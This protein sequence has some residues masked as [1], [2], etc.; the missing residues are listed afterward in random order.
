MHQ[1]I[2]GQWSQNTEFTFTCTMLNH[3]KQFRLCHITVKAGTTFST[4]HDKKTRKSRPLDCNT[5]AQI[6]LFAST[7]DKLTAGLMQNFCLQPKRFMTEQTACALVHGDA[8]CSI[9]RTTWMCAA[10]PSVTV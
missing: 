9:N 5:E 8:N 10:V 3:T 4:K 7:W 2:K 1:F 6:V